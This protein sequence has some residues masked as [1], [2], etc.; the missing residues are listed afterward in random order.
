[1]LTKFSLYIIYSFLLLFC[2][3]CNAIEENK[4]VEDISLE[5][6]TEKFTIKDIYQNTQKGKNVA[7]I[8]AVTTALKD[9]VDMEEYAEGLVKKE[10]YVIVYF[11]EENK[12]TEAI[13]MK[14]VLL[15]PKLRPH[16]MAVYKKTLGVESFTRLPFD[17]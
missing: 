6:S 1:M 4:S 13:E 7:S 12:S 9:Y 14:G 3:G 15:N 5:F 17:S 11:L 2:L 8:Y 10:K 16:C